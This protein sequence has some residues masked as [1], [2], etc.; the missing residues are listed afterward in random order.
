MK[1]RWRCIGHKL[2]KPPTSITRYVMVRTPQGKGRRGRPQ[3]SW[4]KGMEVDTRTMGYTWGRV[5]D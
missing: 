2:R 4:G 5:K 3:Y 1:R